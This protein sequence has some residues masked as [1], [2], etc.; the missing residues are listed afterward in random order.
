MAGH[1]PDVGIAQGVRP[2]L[3]LRRP[4]FPE[5]AKRLKLGRPRIRRTDRMVTEACPSDVTFN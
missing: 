2:P 1:G 4:L 5:E 3:N